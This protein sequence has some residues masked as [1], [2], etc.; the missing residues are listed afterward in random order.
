MYTVLESIATGNPPL[1][2]SQEYAASFVQRIESL[3][4]P[5]RRRIPLIYSHSGIDVRYSCVEDYAR[6]QP[7]EFDFYPPNWSLQL[8][9]RLAIRKSTST[10]T[11]VNDRNGSRLCKN[12]YL[13]I[14]KK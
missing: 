11:G 2:R 7:E 1:R 4:E 10:S 14:E 9:Y 8:E 6:A 5:L 13:V 12:K 3:P